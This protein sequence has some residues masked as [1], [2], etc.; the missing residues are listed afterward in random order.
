MTAP[1]YNPELSSDRSGNLMTRISVSLE[2]EQKPLCHT[3]E[4]IIPFL[5]LVG[6]EIELATVIN[7]EQIRKYLSNFEIE[8]TVLD[9]LVEKPS[10]ANYLYHIQQVVPNYFSKY[11]L[12]LEYFF[13][14]EEEHESLNV[15]V[16]TPMD[17]NDALDAEDLF[18][19][20][21]FKQIYNLTEG[22][23][24]FRVEANGI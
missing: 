11:K 16:Y 9:I 1:A 20:K 14:P 21:E 13:D 18:F 5:S 10:Y 19:E 7:R 2:L 22:K 23:F 4:S 15:V 12:N 8:K 24:T 3:E 17:I 6:D